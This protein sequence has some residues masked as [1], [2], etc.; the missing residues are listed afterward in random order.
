V[1][2]LLVPP[3]GDLRVLS[4]ASWDRETAEAVLGG[5]AIPGLRPPEKGIHRGISSWKLL[6]SEED[7]LRVTLLLG[8]RYTG[9]VLLAGYGP[10]AWLM[11]GIKPGDIL[12]IGAAVVVVSRTQLTTGTQKGRPRTESTAGTDQPNESTLAKGEPEDA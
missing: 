5:E 1:R 7:N 6:D 4:A 9:P 8:G 2:G 10:Q 3:T 11:E 12:E